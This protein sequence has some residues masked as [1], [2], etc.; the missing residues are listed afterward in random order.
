MISLQDQIDA[1]REAIINT[2]HP[3]RVRIYTIAKRLLVRAMHQWT[4]PG[5]QAAA[6]RTENRVKKL[7]AKGLESTMPGRKHERW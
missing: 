4:A 5:K 6:V 1:M 3:R 7:L 2:R